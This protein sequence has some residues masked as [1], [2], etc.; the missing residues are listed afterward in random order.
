VKSGK[1]MEVKEVTEVGR[2][3]VTKAA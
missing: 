2:Q 3:R 1:L